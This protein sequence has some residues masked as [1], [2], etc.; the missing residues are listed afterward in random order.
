MVSSTISTARNA[1]SWSSSIAPSTACSA[2]GLQG[3]ERPTYGSA[4]EKL[5]RDTD[6]IP[7]GLLPVRV[8]EQRGRMVGDDQRNAAVGMNLAPQLAQTLSGVEQRFGRGAAERH[9]HLGPDKRELAVK[10]RHAGCHLVRQRLAVLRR[11]TLHD[12][13]DVYIFAPKSDSLDD[14]VQQLAGLAHEWS[15]HGV[16]GGAR[17][18]ADE[19]QFRVG[20][21]FAR[22]RVGPAGAQRA[23]MGG[24]NP[25]RNGVE[26]SEI[27]QAIPAEQGRYGRLDVDAGAGNGGGASLPL[28]LLLGG[29]GR[30]R[31]D[32]SRRERTGAGGRLRGQRSLRALGGFPPAPV[33]FPPAPVCSRLLPSAPACS[34]LLPS[35]PACS[36]LENHFRAPQ[37]HLLREIAGPL[38]SQAAPPP[39]REWPRRPRASTGAAGSGRRPPGRA[40]RPGWYR[41]RIRRRARARR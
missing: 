25:L 28:R 16:F 5:S 41:A 13:G 14:L 19:H 33:C 2:S 15:P 11:P 4:V 36:R 12:I 24:A 30:E 21:A 7:G 20:I 1:A 6:V 34:R 26:G 8:A 35:A 22:H 39:R 23:T 37:L 27:T 38:V 18:F 3:A 29:S 10:V 32:G 17:S 40:T 9:D 31:A